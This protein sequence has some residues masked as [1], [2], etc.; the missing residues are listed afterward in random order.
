MR[1]IS[2]KTD[3]V[4]DTLP[5]SD[6]NANLRVELQ[7]IVTDAGFSLDPEG[8][9]DTDTDML[10]KSIAVYAN[11]SQYYADTGS[12]DTYEIDRVGNLQPLES[13]LDGTIICFKAAYTN[14]GASTLDVDGLGVKDI[15]DNYGN[16]LVAGEIL[17]N[18]YNFARYNSS[19]DDFE[20]MLPLRFLD[21][22]VQLFFGSDRD[23]QIYFSGT[24][25]FFESTNGNLTIGPSDSYNLIFQTANTARWTV[26]AGNGNLIP[27]SAT[28]DLGSSGTGIANIYQEDSG[29]HYLGSDQ[30]LDIYHSGI[31][32]FISCDN[33]QFRIGTVGSDTFYFKT[34]DVERWEIGPTGNFNPHIANTYDIGTTT[35]LVAN[36]YQGDNG[37]SYYGDSQDAY[38]Y[39]SGTAAIWKNETGFMGIWN[40]ANA[41]MYFYTNNTGRWIIE[42]T[43]HLLPYSPSTYNIGQSGTRVNTIYTVNALDVSDIRYKKEI[44]Q[45]GIGLDFV[46]GLNPISYKLTEVEDDRLRYGLIAQDVKELLLK[47]DLSYDDFCGIH[48]DEKTDRWDMDY[49]MFIGPIIKAIQEL[50]E[51]LDDKANK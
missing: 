33:G 2:S 15:T 14:T 9:P 48:Y 31:A 38:I 32:G 46:Y 12:A 25:G 47:F 11:A 30:D 50:K 7:S 8:G 10:G 36:I 40:I 26:I 3:D 41:N 18:N 42:D 22:G 19:T 20:L 45:C 28:Q 21:D 51:Q 29:H 16:A 27:G 5:A 4:G 43:G 1:N 24:A 37:Y 6:F 49:K 23:M 44:S 17:A 34:V 13:L 35:L 39:H